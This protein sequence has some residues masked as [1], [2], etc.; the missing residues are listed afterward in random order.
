VISFAKQQHKHRVFDTENSLEIKIF[1]GFAPDPTEGAYDAPPDP[2]V[3]WGGG[4]PLPITAPPRPDEV[5]SALR[6]PVLFF[7]IAEGQPYARPTVT[8]PAAE[9]HRPLGG[10]KLYCLVT[11]AHGCQQLA[12]SCCPAMHRPGVKPATSQS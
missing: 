6:P 2:L 10:N 4:Y 8:F 5:P 3:G 1:W 12:Q 9:R 7:H 11:E